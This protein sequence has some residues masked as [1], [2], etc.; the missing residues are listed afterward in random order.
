MWIPLDNA[1]LFCWHD[2]IT[3]DLITPHYGDDMFPAWNMPKKV[4]TSLLSFSSQEDAP[5]PAS[6][7][8][9]MMEIHSV[10]YA[11]VLIVVIIILGH[12]LWLDSVRELYCEQTMYLFCG[13]F[14]VSWTIS[15]IKYERPFILV[16]LNHISKNKRNDKSHPP[17]RWYFR[18]GS[19][20]L[21]FWWLN[22]L[23]RQL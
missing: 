23:G 15:I 19:K 8:E 13:L 11:L 17:K 4:A 1:G 7:N 9:T 22:F 2:K 20:W 12:S 6:S 5:C 3:N 21:N 14:V 18:G 16:L 10:E